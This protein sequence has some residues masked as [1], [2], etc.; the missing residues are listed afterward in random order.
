MAKMNIPVV[1][2]HA[3]N[4]KEY[5]P[6]ITLAI[7]S[8]TFIAL[9]LEMSGIGNRKDTMA[10][11]SDERYKAFCEIAKTRS[12]LSVGI[13]VFQKKAENANDVKNSSD[14]LVQ[15]FNVMLLRKDSF[16]VEPA[17]LKFLLEHG[18]DF[19]THYAK[20]I[21][22]S[23]PRAK[24]KETAKDVNKISDLFFEILRSSKPIVLH[25]GILDLVFLYQNCY[26]DLPSS[27][28]TFLADLSVMFSAGVIDTKYIA[29]YHIGCN[30]TY[31][32]YIFKKS[33]RQNIEN[34]AID[35]SY[36]TIECCKYPSTAD[37]SYNGIFNKTSMSAGS[38]PP[39][40]QY[41]AHGHCP[42]GM[43]CEMS[44]DID[45][46]L[47]YEQQ[48]KAN[49]KRRKRKRK[50]KQ[51]TS[52]QMCG[53]DAAD[54]KKCETNG[55]TVDDVMDVDKVVADERPSN[56]VDQTFGAASSTNS[57]SGNHRAGF[58]AFMTGFCM[59]TYYHR[60]KTQNAATFVNSVSKFLNKL[61]LSGKDIPLKVEK[62][63][64][65]K[66]SVNHNEIWKEVMSSS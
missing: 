65:C 52:S 42:K 61:N 58:D 51:T 31:L 64:Y 17:S 15:T 36:V 35:K 16:I 49:K 41:A 21:P 66:T 7:Q 6:A 1:D 11:D 8:A 47:N 43:Q 54:T 46:I 12:I 2:I 40:E 60:F 5:W 24:V 3:E 39:C 48:K 29:E 53:E 27:L 13:S 18:F 59:A 33:W 9:D 56:I 14:F 37:V 10:R 45:V 26:T 30:A 28:S 63:Q 23:T 38:I 20:A 25:N 19:N 34:E 57:A 4:V 44:H 50:S 22:Y 62:S 32:N 55:S